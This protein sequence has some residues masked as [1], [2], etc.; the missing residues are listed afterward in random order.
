M[1]ISPDGFVKPQP[2]MPTDRWLWTWGRFLI[3][4]AFAFSV[5]IVIQLGIAGP[6]YVAW[7][8]L[9]LAAGIGAWILFHHPAAN[10]FFLL[11]G[12]AVTAD[13]DDGLQVTEALYALYY[14]AFI[15]HWF[16]TRL[17][18]ERKRIFASS[19]E[20]RLA[21]FLLLLPLTL[22]VT[23]L[24]DGSLGSFVRELHA[25]SMLTLFW[26]VKECVREHRN[27]IWIVVGALALLGL[28][29][30][31]RNFLSYADIINNASQAWQ[32]ARGRAVTNE[33]LL[34][35]PSF[36]SLMLF[37]YTE[38]WKGRAVWA[39]CFGLYF[40]GLILTQSRG[41]WASFLFG[42]GIIF[43]I[44][45]MKYRVRMIVSAVIAGVTGILI[46]LLVFGDV[47]LLIVSGLLD[48]FLSI[49]SAA[50]KDLSLVNRFLENAAVWD[51]I[52]MNPVLGY[53]MGTPFRFYDAVWQF[54]MNRSWIHNGYLSLWFR[55]GLWGPL[56]FL[57]V[58]FG[59]A[60]TAFR[61][62]LRLRSGRKS[63]T[64]TV[65]L[66]CLG[67]LAAFSVSTNTSNAFFLSDTLLM[68]GVI[69]G[70][71]HGMDESTRNEEAE[72]SEAGA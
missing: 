6:E 2:G 11:S 31:V 12:F 16:F 14:A 1:Q 34:M 43:L 57:S 37:I 38:K 21:L 50:T 40:T 4:S 60:W 61:T 3:V 58:F 54:S 45:P 72:Q 39:L 15:G 10:L 69:F 32:V 44:V 8:P 67:S 19:T 41:Y 18:L 30:F 20:R 25:L 5:L 56:L 23:L 17:V 27:G 28:A 35:V 66:A 68:L 29:I 22:P 36:I 33:S 13:F 42:T 59:A 9:V 63:M 7:L 53:G 47:L 62:A 71:V 65:S 52:K 46:G 48:R 51:R 24:F 49:Q 70:L 26:P 55:F 64:L